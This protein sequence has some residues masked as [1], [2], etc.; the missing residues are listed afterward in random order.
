MDGGSSLTEL[1]YQ[2]TPFTINFLCLLNFYFVRFSWAHFKTLWP[3]ILPIQN[4]ASITAR[5]NIPYTSKALVGVT[6]DHYTAAEK[7]RCRQEKK[8]KKNW[9]AKKDVC[10]C[11]FSMHPHFSMIQHWQVGNRV[12]LYKTILLSIF[13]KFLCVAFQVS[14]RCSPG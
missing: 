11:R 7:A 9:V 6:G 5:Y 14:R 3:L 12:Q 8:R 10:T 13:V 2:T 4:K 1:A